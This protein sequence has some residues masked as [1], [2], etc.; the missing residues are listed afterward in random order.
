MLAHQ[1]QHSVRHVEYG[2]H[3]DGKHLVEHGFIHVEHGAVFVRGTG[4]VDDDVRDAEGFHAMRNQRLHLVGAGHVAS[5]CAGVCAQGRG[6]AHC[7]FAVDVSHDD[8]RAFVHISFGNAFAETAAR[9]GDD[10]NFVVELCHGGCF[11]KS[12]GIN[13]GIE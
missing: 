1:R 10:G 9:T 6:H 4:V 7:G 3:V 12:E 13:R 5:E 2:F 11:Q 8:A